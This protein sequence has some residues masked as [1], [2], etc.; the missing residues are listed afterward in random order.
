[1]KQRIITALLLA[2][3]ILMI[4]FWVPENIFMLAT[5]LIIFLGAWEWAGL[6]QLEKLWMKI[7]YTVIILACLPLSLLFDARC[8]IIVSCCWWSFAFI[9]IFVYAFKM[10]VWSKTLRG[11]AGILTLVPFWLGLNILRD[12]ASGV[13]LILF[14]I[15]IVSA[16][17]SGAYFAG[18]YF[19]RTKLAPKI[20]PKKT[21]EG[22]IGGVLFAFIIALIFLAAVGELTYL[23]WWSIL[24]LV[25]MLAFFA[26]LGDLFESM[27]K[28]MAQVKDTGGILPGHGG[29]LD[30]IDS[31]TA[32]VSPLVFI[33]SL[34]GYIYL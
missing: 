33:L 18:V 9:S 29:V 16:L 27:I 25:L 21:I 20:S 24:G 3:A 5:T 10:T 23:A 1:M 13:W 8:I 7:V 31:Y 19:G 11:I 12:S 14:L 2:L 30:R 32:V 28:R 6:L 17:D 15:F 26:L 34:A 4:L 22:L